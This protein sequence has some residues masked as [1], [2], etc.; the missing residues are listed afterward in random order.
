[1]IINK[2]EVSNHKIGH[3]TYDLENKIFI[4]TNS[5]EEYSG[6]FMALALF[7]NLNWE[8]PYALLTEYTVVTY[9]ITIENLFNEQYILKLEKEDI[10]SGITKEQLFKINNDNI[11]VIVNSEND[12]VGYCKIPESFLNELSDTNILVLSF[13]RTIANINGKMANLIKKIDDVYH[14]AISNLL[15]KTLEDIYPDKYYY[16]IFTISHVLGEPVLKIRFSNGDYKDVFAIPRE[17]QIV[18]YTFLSAMYSHLTEGE[19]IC[20]FAY[21]EYSDVVEKIANRIKSYVREYSK[22]LLIV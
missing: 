21:N 3:V 9:Y 16:S 11:D 17:E 7:N 14:I 2:I 4:K 13:E 15:K 5:E 19:L 1:M 10:E 20:I 18:I 6:L 22:T 8:S 12:G